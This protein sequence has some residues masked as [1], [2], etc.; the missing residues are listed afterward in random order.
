MP[1][2]IV[3]MREVLE[4]RTGSATRVL[5]DVAD[6]TE[7]TLVG[8]KVSDQWVWQRYGQDAKPEAWLGD[9]RVYVEHQVRNAELPKPN[10]EGEVWYEIN[11]FTKI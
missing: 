3:K 6:H 2:P 5:W 8:T 7:A 11:T 9:V 4:A 10:A 1:K